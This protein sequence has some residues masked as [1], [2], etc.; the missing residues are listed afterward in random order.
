MKNYKIGAAV[1]VLETIRFILLRDNSVTRGQTN[2][3]HDSFTRGQPP[4][5]VTGR[6]RI[7]SYTHMHMHTHKYIVYWREENIIIDNVE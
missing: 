6:W 7:L 3:R 4:V 2:V 1:Q 5:S